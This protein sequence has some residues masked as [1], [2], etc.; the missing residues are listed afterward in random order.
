[1]ALRLHDEQASLWQI[2][3]MK[4]WQKVESRLFPFCFA[5]QVVK[6]YAVTASNFF[7]SKI[8]INL[9]DKVFVSPLDELS[10]KDICQPFY[11][12]ALTCDNGEH[13]SCK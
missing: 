7:L 3:S 6:I 11:K 8:L 4:N 9:I 10:S 13:C 1:M 12:Q 5:L 2:N